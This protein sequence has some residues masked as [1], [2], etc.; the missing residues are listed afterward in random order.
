MNLAPFI[1]LN[2]L[3]LQLTSGL[4]FCCLKC[5][6]SKREKN[7][8][9]KIQITWSIREKPRK[10]VC[11]LEHHLPDG[12]GD[13]LPRAVVPDELGVLVRPLEDVHCRL[14]VVPHG[15]HEHARQETH[16]S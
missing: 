9:Q 10:K 1:D 12:G 8:R 2:E 14:R 15:V 16:Q 4:S 7:M 6:Q 5:L 13:G 11:V 3:T